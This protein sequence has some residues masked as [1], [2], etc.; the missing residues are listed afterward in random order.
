MRGGLKRGADL[1]L[2]SG[3]LL[4]SAPLLGAAALGVWATLGRPVFFVEDRCGRYERPFR[5]YKVRTMR[6]EP[7]E[8]RDPAE[9]EAR[10]PPLGRWLRR[11]HLDELPQLVN[12]LR[13]EMSLVG[14]RPL[15]MH[16]LERYSPPGRRRHEARPGLT[17]AAQCLHRP[18]MS[19]EERE[20]LDL[21]YVSAPPSL[22]RDA[23]ILA[24]TVLHLVKK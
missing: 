18:D 23:R 5:I 12:V 14:P 19:W 11:A 1:V 13:G 6:G 16:Y 15:Y 20:A 24:A 21:A 17:G 2:G 8:D 10:T 9:D 7:P 4:V 3:L 22:L